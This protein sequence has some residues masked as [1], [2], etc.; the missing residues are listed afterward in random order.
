MGTLREQIASLTPE[1][2]ALLQQ[3]LEQSNSNGA[4]GESI[5]RRHKNGPCALSFAQERL[6]FL[7]QFEPGSP[8]YNIT[9]ALHIEGPLDSGALQHALDGIVRRH[10]SLRTVFRSSEGAAVQEVIPNAKLQLETVSLAGSDVSETSIMT[11]L[12]AEARRPFNLLQ[13][14]ALRATLLRCRED[15]HW[16]LLVL[17]HIASDGWSMGVLLREL[18]ELYRANCTGENPDLPELPIQYSDFAVWQ[19]EWLRGENL[20]KQAAYWQ[21]RLK[22]AP[23]LLE[24]P[25]DHPRPAQQTL[26]GAREPIRLSN[27]LTNSL[28]AFSRSEG[29]T[30]FMTLLSALQTLLQRHT[31]QTDIC[32]GTAIANRNRVELEPMIGFF[33]NTLVLRSDLSGSPS[34]RKLLQQVRNVALEAYAHPDLPFEHL[35]DILQPGRNLS[36]SPLFQVMFILQNTPA[37]TLHLPGTTTREHKI[38]N[39]SAKFDLTLS[40]EDAG[41]QITGWIEY[42]TD[43]FRAATIRRIAGH[44]LTLLESI[45]QNP[46]Q[47][48][49]TLPILTQSERRQ[50]LVEWNATRQD[51][52]R[53]CVHELFQAQVAER[54]DSVALISGEQQISYG[55][56]N[57]RANQL[58]H[59]LQ[60][61]GVGPNSAVGICVERSPELLVA[62]LGV[63]KAGGAY[64]PLDPAFPRERLLFMLRDSGAKVLLTEEHLRGM[65]SESTAR[66]ICLDS[67]WTAVSKQS[68]EDCCNGVAPDNLAYIIYTSGSTGTPKG[69]EIPHRALTNFLFSMKSCPGLMQED[70]LLAITTAS[71]DIA[72]LEFYLP[73]TVGARIV[74]ASREAASDGERLQEALTA[75]QATCMQ[76]TPTTWRMLISTG[77]KGSPNLKALCGGEALPRDLAEDLLRCVRELWNMYGPTETTIWSGVHRITLEKGPVL[78]GRPIANTEFYVLD[79]HRQLVPVGVTGD[80]YIGGDGLALGYRNRPELTA[81][82]FVSLSFTQEPGAALYN[83]G[84]MARYHA[85]G[86]V[87]LLGRRDNQVKLRGFRV[88]LGEV[89]ASLCEHPAIQAA[90]TVVREDPAGDQ[91]L[92]AYVVLQPGSPAR[93]EELRTFLRSKLPDYMLPARFEFLDTLPLTLNGKI[94]RR[95]LPAPT[96]ERLENELSYVAPRTELDKKLASIWA[97]VLQVEHIG[98]HD[99]FFDLGGHSLLAVKLVARIEKVFGQKVPVISIFQLP[100]IA[101]FATLL[102]S[103]ARVAS[104]DKKDG[105]VPI[106]PNG[107]KTPFFCIGAGPFFRP[108]ALR[109]GS[110][111]PFLGLTT[112]KSDIANLPVPFK[113]EDIAAGL[114]RKL[115]QLQPHGPYFLGGWCEDGVFAYEMAQQ[116]RAQG[117]KVALLV[118]FEARN[119][120]RWKN[121]SSLEKS[122]VRLRRPFRKIAFHLANLRR[123]GIRESLADYKWRLQFRSIRHKVW[124][125]YYRFLLAAQGKVDDRFRK[126]F[127]A[128]YISVRDYVPKPYPERTL[129]VRSGLD[130]QRITDPDLGWASLLVGKWEFHFVPGGH[131]RI[132]LEPNVDRLASTLKRCLLDAQE[133]ENSETALAGLESKQEAR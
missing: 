99:N 113:L 13:D 62:L 86:N 22:D 130:P 31:G 74:L 114:V 101:E 83:T 115:R 90:A 75:S 80:L 63:L 104:N 14:L 39:G 30:L 72:A 68:F 70:I 118:L 59:H 52:P 132:F 111:Q 40:L 46:D 128:G 73:L 58:A 47:S 51:C 24:L 102:S 109:L 77:W 20:E 41:G 12:R 34:F 61:M 67:D 55:Q 107:S 116:L 27:T 2:R 103:T 110:D 37:R 43:L 125:A 79:A 66:F 49:A 25:T 91:R 106:Q 108:L 45:L 4:H 57:R 96:T 119:P 95:A 42:N 64:V 117:D 65:L 32:V 6:W 89:E 38:D 44:Y 121:Y 3:R 93:T 50:L 92:V 120:A 18:G 133:A 127:R 78:I 10:E 19:R 88:E 123:I 85:D 36:Y 131:R 29:V 81:E 71:F 56:L 23:S 1:Q 129:L 28:R 16:L 9:R 122:K 11:R 60:A 82:K 26:A 53:N 48:I 21:Q 100:T 87:E 84:D 97:E 69:V 7:D 33:V 112:V 94:D 76:A 98:L 8:V 105:V 126:F 35:V 54:P 17:H 15:D 124:Y 5:P